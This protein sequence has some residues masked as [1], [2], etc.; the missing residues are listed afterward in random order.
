MCQGRI[1]DDPLSG[2]TA[3]PYSTGPLPETC[4][5]GAPSEL[6][7][8]VAFDPDFKYPQ[9]L[10]ASAAWD[11]EITDNTSF[12]LGMIFTHAVHQVVLEDLNLGDPCGNSGN[13]GDFGGFERRLFGCPDS[14]GFEPN[15]DYPQ[16]Q[17]VLVAKNE[18]RDWAFTLTAEMRGRIMDRMRYQLG[19]TYGRSFDRMSLA[20]TDMISNYGFTPTFRG[21]NEASLRASNFDRPHKVVASIFGAP[22]PGLPNTEISLLYT[23]QSGAPFSYVYEGDMNGDG[24]PGLGSA[25]DR[26]ND[27]LYVPETIEEVPG[28][29]AALGLIQYALN[30]DACLRRNRG[31]FLERNSCR[32]PWQNRLDLRFSHS[33]DF[34]GTE[35]R[36]E[37]DLINV[38]NAINRDW[39]NIETVRS[40]VA[41]IGLDRES[42]GF[43]TVGNLNAS[44]AGAVLPNR[45]ADGALRPTDPWSIRSPDSQWQAQFGLRVTIG[46]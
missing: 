31:D 41:L 32:A 35:F 8:I 34:G 19:Y 3:P 7:P 11:Q 24:F 38:L 4:F 1:T 29:P 22:I 30:N 40:N 37:G 36:F 16:F 9:E 25:F 14:D 45:D 23:G 43:G 2:N 6:T 46:N 20:F 13:F 10:R 15:R 26:F 12:S 27:L 42:G 39:G 21:P 17:Q 44:W 28:S 5:N 18:S 33:F